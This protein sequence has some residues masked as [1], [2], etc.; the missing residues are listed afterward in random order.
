MINK[1]VWDAERKKNHFTYGCA[2]SPPFKW[3]HNLIP[4]NYF[5]ITAGNIKDLYVGVVCESY[6]Y[7]Y[8]YS[9]LTV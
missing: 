4:Q 8:F 5:H 1:L 9:T 2:A 3:Q 6:I 7:T